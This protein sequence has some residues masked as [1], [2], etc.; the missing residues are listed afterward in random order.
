MGIKYNVDEAFFNSWNRRMAY[1]LGYIYADGSMEYSPNIRGKYVRIS[2]TDK[3]SIERMRGWLSSSHTITRRKSQWKN[4]KDL[5]T[6]RIGSHAL[7]NSLTKHGLY[8][9]KSLTISVPEISRKYFM[10][11]VRGY[12]DGDGCVHLEKIVRRDGKVHV[13]KLNTIFTSGCRSFLI[14]LS[15]L[16]H[17][18]IGLGEQTIIESWTA[19]Q[20]RY[21]TKDSA[22]LCKELYKG[23]KKGEYLERKHEIYQEFLILHKKKAMWRR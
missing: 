4:G 17:E 8:P 7:Y 19:Y 22:I 5:F 3:D 1:T 23:C 12:F 10:D 14:Q 11:F 20:L 15:R 16:L 21:S 6:I 9:N 13:R 18:Y 2:S